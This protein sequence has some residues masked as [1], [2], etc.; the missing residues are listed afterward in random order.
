MLA[1]L[2]ADILT[3]LAN[4]DGLVV[5]LQAFHDTQFDEL[6]TSGRWV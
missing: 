1:D 3:K 4:F 6:A 2:D 5:E